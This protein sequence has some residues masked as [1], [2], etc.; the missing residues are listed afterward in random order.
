MLRE[1]RAFA[2]G[3]ARDFGEG[4]M[5]SIAGKVPILSDWQHSRALPDN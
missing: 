2:A 5:A 3:R 4:E 1:W